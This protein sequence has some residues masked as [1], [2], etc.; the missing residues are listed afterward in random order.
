MQNGKQVRATVYAGDYEKITENGITREFY[1]LDGNTIVVKQNGAF[2]NFVAFTDNIGNI[3]SVIDEGGSKMFD[4]SYDAWGNQTIR[5]NRIGLHRGYTGHEMLPEF[6]IINMNGRLYD[7]VLG[8]FLSPDN[9]VQSPYNSQ[10]F[11][12]YSYCLNNPLKYT[13]PSG[14][15][16]D[17]ML[18]VAIF[19]VSSSVMKAAYNGDNVWKSCASSAL[20]SAASYGLSTLHAVA[21]YGIGQAFGGVGSFGNEMLRAGA[22]GVSGGVFS[23]L[24]G[25]SFGSGF[26]SGFTSSLV[27]SLTAG[28][29]A[30][31]TAASYSTSSGGMVM[32]GE[33]SNVS[34]QTFTS[35]IVG[36]L[37][38]WAT[39]GDF[40]RGATIGYNVGAFNHAMHDGDGKAYRKDA[41]GNVEGGELPGVI[42][43]AKAPKVKFNVYMAA[44]YITNHAEAASTHYCATYVRR[45]LEYGGFNTKGHPKYAK[46]WGRTLKKGGYCEV[47]KKD[48]CPLIGDIRVFNSYP[49]GSEGGHI[50]MWNGKN[51]VSDWI[52]KD[53]FPGSG[54]EKANDYTIYS[55]LY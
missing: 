22:H 44:A 55:F 33:M 54:Y 25:G 27:C 18:A 3:L 8:R 49:G 29:V 5:Q 37:A 51:W 2:R 47:P 38:A 28:N 19:N 14:N 11:N 30:D 43:T 9:Y 53:W 10:N 26:A 23:V 46:N 50:D 42:A 32:A 35:S 21:S 41:H 34:F 12:R 1:Y 17:A 20:K 48:Y 39:G 7:P 52:E 45:A 24:D 4:A 13:D 16:I 31:D 36:G 40:L 6:G 15:L